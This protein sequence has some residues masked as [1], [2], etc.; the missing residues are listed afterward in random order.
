VKILSVLTFDANAPH[1]H[2]DPDCPDRMEGLV[3]EMRAKGVLLD[4]GGRAG[5]MLEIKIARKNGKTSVT[6]GP[7]TEAKEVVGGYAL[8]EVKDREEAVAWTHRFLDVLGSGTCY[9]HEVFTGP[10]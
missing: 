5:Q 8:L 1:P 2:E 10:E 4:T 7:F 9:M 3:R 6:D